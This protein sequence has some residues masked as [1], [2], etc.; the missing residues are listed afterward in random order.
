MK[1]LIV[2]LKKRRLFAE[3]E[4][5]RKNNPFRSIESLAVFC[6]RL[7]AD[8]YISSAILWD[9]SD[10]G[11]DFWNSIHQERLEHLKTKKGSL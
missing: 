8:S 7:P 5:L 1:E 6:K 3:F 9:D 11:Y 4:R 2:F 10:K